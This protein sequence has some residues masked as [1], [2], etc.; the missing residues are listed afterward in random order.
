MS[1]F[2][3]SKL[4]IIS[5]PHEQRFQIVEIYFKKLSLPPHYIEPSEKAQFMKLLVVYALILLF[6]LQNYQ[7][8]KEICIMKRI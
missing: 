5:R 1:K 6:S 4:P 3:A 2:L 8:E 7:K